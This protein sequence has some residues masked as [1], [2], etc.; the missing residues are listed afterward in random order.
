[1][2]RQGRDALTLNTLTAT[3]RGVFTLLAM[4]LSTLIHGAVVVPGA[5][6]KFLV[7]EG[8]WR[9]SV[10][11][12]LT[13]VA[14]S[15]IGVNNF[16]ISRGGVAWDIQIPERLNHNGCYLVLCNHQ[17]W[18]DILVLQRCFNRRLPLLRFFLKRQLFWVPVLGLCWWGLDFP[19]MRRASRE[20]LA[21]RPELRGRDLESARRACE[22]FRNVPV[23][24]MSFPEGTRRAGSKLA[25]DS[26]FRHLLAPKAGGA[27][28]VIYALGDQLDGC[29]DVTIAYDTNTASKE[30][31]S[32]WAL[33]SGTL[34]RIRVR[35]ALCEIPE[36]LLDRDFTADRDARAAL[37]EWVS[38]IWH[39]KDELLDKLA[40]GDSV[41]EGG[42]NTHQD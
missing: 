37:Q 19:F 10:R 14:E 17:S 20:E 26:E 22:M 24:M 25:R 41:V 30:P 38:A 32:F 7:P 29:V 39:A 42:L 15:W 34:P 35:A 13:R 16:L 31:P 18:A 3:L 1:M 28:A 40:S 33:I 27:G 21:R 2:A 11:K 23:A 36:N 8:S 9:Q 5:L 4:G 12:A 6:V